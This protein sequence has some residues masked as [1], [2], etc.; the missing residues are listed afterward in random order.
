[1]ETG[2]Y[3]AESQ[4]PPS[5]KWPSNAEGYTLL[6]RIGHGAFA[7]VY[8]AKVVSGPQADSDVAGKG[9][10]LG[11]GPLGGVPGRPGC[12]SGNPEAQNNHL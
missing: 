5:T 12:R 6:S 3:T 4:S 2:G 7:T 10:E 11:E 9:I 8:K 1:M